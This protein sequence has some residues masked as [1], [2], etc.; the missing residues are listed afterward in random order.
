MPCSNEES[1]HWHG[2]NIDGLFPFDVVLPHIVE[3]TFV[4]D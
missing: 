4:F 3:T 1:F 2:L